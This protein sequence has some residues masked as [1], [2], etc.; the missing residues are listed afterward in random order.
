MMDF[1]ALHE[2]AV[3]LSGQFKKA[4]AEL[5]DILI[6]IDSRR[7]F[8]RMGFASLWEYCLRGLKLSE[9]DADN[10]IRIARKSQIV[11]ELKKAVQEGQINLS[12]AR[13]ICSVITNENKE[14]WLDLAK[15]L[16]QK[17][18][19][20]EIVKENP[21]VKVPDKL[22]PLAP[23][24]TELHC[25]VSEEVEGLMRRVLDLESKRQKK[26]CSL[27]DALRQM[28]L[29]YLEKNDPVK[30]AERQKN[31][32]QS[33]SPVLRRVPNNARHQVAQRDQ[34]QCVFIDEQGHRCVQRRFTDIHHIQPYS[35]GGR[36]EA[37]NLATL[38]S[39]HHKAIHEGITG[40]RLA[41]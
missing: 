22:K 28:A 40:F 39:T 20:K 16:P 5:L 35:I 29:L 23:K 17:E 36:H 12:A 41:V 38:C 2:R 33:D 3:S 13:R 7:V 11:P 18:L 21:R 30:K 19:E 9:S 1:K 26:N 10:F 32:Q 34:G 37:E 25:S 4:Q 8:Q 6:E 15:T 24:L 31:T 14:Q 27:E